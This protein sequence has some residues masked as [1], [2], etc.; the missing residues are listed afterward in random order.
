MEWLK[1]VLFPSVPS[2]K[3]KARLVVTNFLSNIRSWSFCIIRKKNHRYELQ[4]YVTKNII[5]RLTMESQKTRI[6]V[7]KTPIMPLHNH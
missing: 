5:I 1:N 3:I 6:I 2:G 4:L 7:A